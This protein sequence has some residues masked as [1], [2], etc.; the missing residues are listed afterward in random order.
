MDAKGYIWTLTF[1]LSLAFLRLNGQATEARMRID[2]N[3]IMI[4]DQINLTLEL[5]VPKQSEVFWPYFQYD[6]VAERVEIIE[7]FPVDS[8]DLKDRY[9]RIWQILTITSFDT[10]KYTIRP[11]SFEFKLKGDTT[12]YAIQSNPVFLEV[13]EPAVDLQSEIKAIKPPL[14]APLTFRE[15]M[16]FVVRYIL[17]VFAVLLVIAIVLYVILR[18]KKDQPI[19]RIRSKPPLPPHRQALD[20]LEALRLKKLW[21]TGRVK[22]YYSELT[23][24]IRTYI[25]R[26]FGV[27]ALEMTSDDIIR[28]LKS[29]NSHGES[30]AKLNQV[31]VLADLV[32]FAKEQPLPS[33][34][35]N[36]MTK[37]I[38]FVN[39]TR[40]APVPEEKE[41]TAE[42]MEEKE[43]TDAE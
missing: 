4:G 21:Q 5:D 43:K 42:T 22:A 41:E 24:I 13:T 1:L 23:G 27:Q 37:S 40:P 18:R 38:D 30:I 14:E 16:A 7:E 32:K 28:E 31:L 15:V 34:N 12:V 36:C 11:V 10:G 20:D 8:S 29:V 17:P 25:E 19:F 2:T 35:D 39:E 6:T 9:R 33:D 3:V 26:R